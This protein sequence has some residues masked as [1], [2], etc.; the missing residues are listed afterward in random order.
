MTIFEMQRLLRERFPEDSVEFRECDDSRLYWRLFFNGKATSLRMS[1]SSIPT[2][3]GHVKARFVRTAL[4]AIYREMSSD[5]YVRLED[6]NLDRMIEPLSWSHGP[7]S[8]LT[9][10][11]AKCRLSLWK[12][13]Y[14]A[15]GLE[16]YEPHGYGRNIVRTGRRSLHEQHEY[17]CLDCGHV[18]WSRHTDIVRFPLEVEDDDG[19]QA[20]QEQRQ[21][22]SV[23]EGGTPEH[24]VR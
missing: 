15:L 22:E 1:A 19:K 24:E 11:C 4:R 6:Q 14:E 16:K 8:P 17:R 18:G 10:Y 23:Q 7:G 12:L 13:K 9:F 20:K 2:P 3:Y 5:D 21:G